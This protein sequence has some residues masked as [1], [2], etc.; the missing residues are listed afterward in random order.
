[1]KVFETIIEALVALILLLVTLWAGLAEAAGPELRYSTAADCSGALPLAGSTFSGEVCLFYSPPIGVKLV[2]HWNQ[3]LDPVDSYPVY[4]GDDI[5]VALG[6]VRDVSDDPVNYQKDKEGVLMVPT[7]IGTDF[8][9]K[10]L[11]WAKDE[12]RCFRLRARVDYGNDQGSVESGYSEAVCTTNPSMK[13][14]VYYIDDPTLAGAPVYR[15]T[16][17]PWAYVGTL[18]VGDHTMVAVA[19]FTG[20]VAQ[21]RL[22]ADFTIVK[23]PPSAPTNFGIGVLLVY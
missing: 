9:D 22:E 5:T 7:T 10:E 8:S 23:K 11:G 2:L 21:E 17:A 15:A 16:A 3:N 14:V 12:Q 19:N 1:M 6:E 20:G 4:M 18:A 13:E